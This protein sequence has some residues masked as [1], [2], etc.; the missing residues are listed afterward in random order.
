MINYLKLNKQLQIKKDLLTSNKNIF[1][2]VNKFRYFGAARNLPGVKELLEK[3][4][5]MN[6]IIVLNFKVPNTKKMRKENRGIDAD[7]YGYRFKSLLLII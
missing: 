4:G 7:Y 2:F 1:A 6:L 5:K 3:S